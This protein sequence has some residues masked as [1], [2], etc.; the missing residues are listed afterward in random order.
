MLYL[1][2]AGALFTVQE[3]TLAGCPAAARLAAPDPP[4]GFYQVYELDAD[5]QARAVAQ[6]S[7]TPQGELE[8]QVGVNP[9]S[10][11]QYERKQ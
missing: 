9:I 6:V 1:V 7:G 8:A 5:G 2:D 10:P 11:H 3:A 4:G